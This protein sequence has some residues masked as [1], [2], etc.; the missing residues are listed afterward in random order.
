MGSSQLSCDTASNSPRLSFRSCNYAFI[1]DR[2]RTARGRPTFTNDMLYSWRRCCSRRNTSASGLRRQG[3]RG[4][5]FVQFYQLAY[6]MHF[7][8][9]ACRTI[10][11]VCVF[12]DLSITTEPYCALYVLNA[13]NNALC[14]RNK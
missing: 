1:I 3:Q 10:R 11:R 13:P 5:Y 8:L 7:G 6:Y 12:H 4:A 9:T 14:R 2:V